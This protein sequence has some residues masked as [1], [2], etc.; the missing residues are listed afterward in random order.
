[1][2]KDGR[3]GE[4]ALRRAGRGVR[5]HTIRR[6]MYVYLP[7]IAAGAYFVAE[8]GLERLHLISEGAAFIM[9]GIVGLIIP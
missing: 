5:R 9:V 8:S 7:T 3:G 6:Q 2:G 1:M 4:Q